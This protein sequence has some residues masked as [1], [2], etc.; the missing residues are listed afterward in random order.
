MYYYYHIYKQ[1]LQIGKCVTQALFDHRCHAMESRNLDKKHK[2]IRFFREIG[3]LERCLLCLAKEILG[4]LKAVFIQNQ[5]VL[6]VF[7][8]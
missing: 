1:S 5:F 6:L 2:Q 8:L 4:N 3:L 7:R